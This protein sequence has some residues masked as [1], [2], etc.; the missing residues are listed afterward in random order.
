[1]NKYLILA[2]GGQVV[3]R[4]IPSYKLNTDNYRGVMSRKVSLTRETSCSLHS[5]NPYIKVSLCNFRHLESGLFWESVSLLTI[6]TLLPKLLLLFLLR[7][8]ADH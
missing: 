6:H 8:V 7:L 1:M 5:L 4:E 3:L 2:R